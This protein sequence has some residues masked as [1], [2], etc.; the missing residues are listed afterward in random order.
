MTEEE[1]S[2]EERVQKRRVDSVREYLRNKQALDDPA[3]RYDV[4]P[5]PGVLQDLTYFPEKLVAMREQVGAHSFRNMRILRSIHPWIGGFNK[6]THEPES[7]NQIKIYHYVGVDSADQ[8]AVLW[9]VK[10]PRTFYGAEQIGVDYEKKQVQREKIDEG[11][12]V[13]YETVLVPKGAKHAIKDLRRP[14]QGRAAERKEYESRGIAIWRGMNSAVG[15]MARMA[16]RICIMSLIGW[17]G[18]AVVDPW[19]T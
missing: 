19:R 15:W 16:L 3:V 10:G 1:E 8:P 12:A 6:D 17:Q 7:R 14:P 11:Q 13:E 4:T 5:P 2:V 18:R 9:D